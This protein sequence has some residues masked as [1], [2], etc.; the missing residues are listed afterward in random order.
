MVL[1]VCSL[2]FYDGVAC[3]RLCVFSLW[4]VH[5][6]TG[7][8]KFGKI[9]EQVSCIIA[10]PHILLTKKLS[11][12][13]RNKE[14]KTAKPAIYAQHSHHESSKSGLSRAL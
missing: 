1:S 9:L 11:H 10:M 7:L 2:F 5:C 14:K 12:K 4:H 6:L 3:G 8:L 13:L